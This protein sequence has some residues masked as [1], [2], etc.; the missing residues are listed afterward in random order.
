MVKILGKSFKSIDEACNVLG[1]EYD[2]VAN[3]ARIEGVS[4]YIA[5][6]SILAADEQVEFY[7]K[8]IKPEPK[9]SLAEQI[10]KFGSIEARSINKQSFSKREVLERVREAK[11][12]KHN[13]TYVKEIY[14]RCVVYKNKSKCLDDLINELDRYVK[15]LGTKVYNLTNWILENAP[16]QKE[17]INKAM[18]DEDSRYSFQ[19]TVKLFSSKLK[20]ALTSAII[21]DNVAFIEHDTDRRNRVA[22]HVDDIIK[23]EFTKNYVS[24]LERTWRIRFLSIKEFITNK[25]IEK[26]LSNK[27]IEVGES[28]LAKILKNYI[29]DIELCRNKE[30][31]RQRKELIR[32]G[33][34]NDYYES[35]DDT[36]FNLD[37]LVNYIK[38][39]CIKV[40]GLYWSSLG[41]VKKATK[42]REIEQI[43]ENEYI[44]IV[45][46]ESKT[47][48][49]LKSEL[50]KADPELSNLK[51]L[52]A[53]GV[54][55]REALKAILGDRFNRIEDMYDQSDLCNILMIPKSKVNTLVSNKAAE[56]KGNID[57]DALWDAAITVVCNS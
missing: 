33:G 11:L 19:S 4:T 8:D 13:Y 51:G 25:G 43:S 38:S 39:N 6:R 14:D 24:E 45:G 31:D 15:D 52:L 9:K 46:A 34:K 30:L 53:R 1:I 18:N 54:N 20:E 28:E 40:D 56:M 48:D 10:D 49:T 41:S 27:G 23:G 17:A 37:K 57:Y 32:V 3:T 44:A 50:K 36:V 29:S 55:S 26:E 5:L 12:S 35:S 16:G 2:E 22:K 42:V 47:E 21:N 7:T